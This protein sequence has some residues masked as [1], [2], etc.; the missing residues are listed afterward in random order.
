MNELYE[1]L[2]Q[3]NENKNIIKEEINNLKKK[4]RI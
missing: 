2:E 1:I 3:I 4:M